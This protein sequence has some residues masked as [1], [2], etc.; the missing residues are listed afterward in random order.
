MSHSRQ[1]NPK[2]NIFKRY[3]K[4][5]GKGRNMNNYPWTKGNLAEADTAYGDPYAV[6]KSDGSELDTANMTEAEFS[7]IRPGHI[8]GSGVASILGISPWTTV[9][10][11]YNQFISVDPVLKVEFNAKAKAAGH[12]NEE[13]VAQKFISYM[14]KYENTDIELCNDSCVFRNKRFPWA[15]VNLDRRIVKINGKKADAILECKTTGFRN[16]HSIN[17][18]WKKGICPPYYEA[19]V[20]FYLM[21]MNVKTAYICCCWGLTDDEMA[22]IRIDRNDEL[23]KPI[24]TACEDFVDC[25][26][27][28]I[29]PEETN[30]SS[31]LFNNAWLRYNGAPDEQKTPVEFPPSILNIVKK[32]Q[33]LEEQIKK[34]EE[35]LE[36]DKAAQQDILKALL[37]LYDGA[38]YG[39]VS[40]DDDATGM[41]KIYSVKLKVSMKRAK[42]DEENFKKDHP[43]LWDAYKKETLDLTALGKKEKKVKAKYTLPAEVDPTKGYK[44]E[45]STKDIPI[46]ENN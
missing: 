24:I 35:K 34:D 42:F 37:P 45:I 19:Q 33:E 2:T 16:M 31:E 43:D 46:P 21:V 27:Q 20:R 13:F 25:V 40:E 14:K 10:E 3:R 12:E 29:I 5:S 44:F 6:I 9:T 11:Y 28:G 22:V 26:D 36:A 1:E 18:Y 23:E 41:R 38:E 30:K 4:N 15:Q 39:S 7:A 17:E 32:A 8:G